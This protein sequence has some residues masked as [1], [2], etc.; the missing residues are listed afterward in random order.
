MTEARASPGVAPAANRA[1][2]R[3]GA[4]QG[5]GA[6]R[7]RRPPGPSWG[8]P[9]PSCTRFMIRPISSCLLYTSDAADDMQ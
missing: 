9:S 5:S 4:S 3:S 6:D 2:T 1:R 8:R 7:K